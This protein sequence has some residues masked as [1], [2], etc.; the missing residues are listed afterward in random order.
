MMVNEEVSGMICNQ[1]VVYD[2]MFVCYQLGVA[3]PFLGMYSTIW[4]TLD[5]LREPDEN[6]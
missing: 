4:R 3:Q 2:F 1:R 5:T 6:N